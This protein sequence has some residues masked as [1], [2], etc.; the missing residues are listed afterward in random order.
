MKTG[1]F[2]FNTPKT[3]DAN[4]TYT[5]GDGITLNGT[6]FDLDALQTIITS[7]YNEAL[8]VGRDADNHIDFTT[9][10]RINFRVSAADEVRLTSVNFYPV[11]S[12]GTALGT[13]LQQW[14]DLFLANLGVI[15]WNNGDV[16]LTSDSNKLTL[17]GGDLYLPNQ[18]V[19]TDVN[20]NILFSS[21]TNDIRFNVGGVSEYIMAVN[22]FAPVTD[23]GSALGAATRK[24]SDLFLAGGGVVNFNNGNATITNNAAG[25]LTISTSDAGRGTIIPSRNFGITSSTHGEAVGDVVNFGSG[26]VVAGKCYYLTSGGAWAL[27]DRRTEA[28]AIS[29]LAVA[30]AT[31][32]ASAVGMCIRGMVTMASDTG[33]IGSVTYLRINGDFEGAATTTSGEFVR[34]MGYCLDDTN[35]QMF[36]NPSTDWVEIA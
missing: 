10:N 31:G 23:N 3:T 25:Q 34:I 12:N 15:N 13:N 7:I 24:W 5:A 19:G 35:G 2:G 27:A 33:T 22:L 28:P 11:T 30:L 1:N 6:E 20:T 21:G 26:S 14:S 29:F 32:T 16:T 17:G 36:F 4:T 9:D 8:K 18:R